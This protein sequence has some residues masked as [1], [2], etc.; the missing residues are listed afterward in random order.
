MGGHPPTLR[1]VSY[2]GLDKN[3]LSGGGAQTIVRNNLHETKSV[4]IP[5]TLREYVLKT[6]TSWPG[7]ARP[8]V[9][10]ITYWYA[11]MHLNIPRRFLDHV[12]RKER[13]IN[14][15][16]LNTNVLIVSLLDR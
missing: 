7:L 12:T 11:A 6:F 16:T 2:I 13:Q 10:G 14:T 3:S 8:Q 4:L 9:H 15:T 1:N 5:V